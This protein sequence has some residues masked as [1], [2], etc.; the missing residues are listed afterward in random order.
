MS[1]KEIDSA[2]ETGLFAPGN[3]E[4]F[5]WGLVLV[6]AGIAYYADA[7]H[8]IRDAWDYIAPYGGGFLLVYWSL[9]RMMGKSLSYWMLATGAIVFIAWVL[10]RWNLKLEY[11]PL[12]LIILGVALLIKAITNNRPD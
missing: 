7:L 3:V 12:L 6:F 5:G 8:N 10:D 1:D 11:W 9:A 4:R 2:Q